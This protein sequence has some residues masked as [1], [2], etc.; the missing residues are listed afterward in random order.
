M[1]LYQLDLDTDE[2][3]QEVG[4]A[5]LSSERSPLTL[6]PQRF[7]LGRKVLPQALLVREK[8]MEYTGAEHID[9]RS[10]HDV[11]SVGAR[12]HVCCQPKAR[13]PRS[14]LEFRQTRLL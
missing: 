1:R 8:L 10:H 12:P 13:Q 5:P 9:S 4:E 7:Q 6:E 14:P 11:S 2:G 3:E